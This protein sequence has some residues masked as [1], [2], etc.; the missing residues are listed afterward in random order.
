VLIRVLIVDDHSMV[1]QGLQMYFE[2]DPQ[3]EIV[4]E[5]RNGEEAIRLGQALEPQ[6]VL[7]D[8]L[9][10]VL[11]GFQAIKALRRMLPRAHIVAMTS[12]VEE[13]GVHRAI[14]AGAI[15][16]V[17]KDTRPDE[18]RAAVLAAAE[19]R[20]RLP[21]ESAGR[22]MQDA[23]TPDVNP[24]NLTADQRELLTLLAAGHSTAEISDA[25]DCSPAVVDADMNALLARLSL[26][27]RAQAVLYATRKGLV[28]PDLRP[29]LV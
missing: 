8:L 19:G 14:E 7:M 29:Y 15:S 21:S 5:A 1:R 10:P 4:G 23:R 20:V 18:L 3:V 22:L 24:E 27:G 6:V 11:D 26:A 12:V 17:L 28:A 16:Y 13:G 25:R 9:M 2:G